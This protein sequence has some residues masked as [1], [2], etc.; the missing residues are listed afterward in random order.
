[1]THTTSGLANRLPLHGA[2]RA[3]REEADNDLFT[4]RAGYYAY[5]DTWNISLNEEL[6]GKANQLCVW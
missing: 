4:C 2:S 3:D 6:T 5:Q 1:M